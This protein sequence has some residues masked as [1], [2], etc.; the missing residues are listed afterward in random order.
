MPAKAVEKQE[1]VKAPEK[2]FF[3]GGDSPKKDIA[4][5]LI[6]EFRISEHGKKIYP[7]TTI[8]HICVVNDPETGMP[9]TMRLLKGIKTFWVD[10]QENVSDKM[11]QN[12]AEDI[13]ITDG[14]LKVSVVDKLK[15]DFLRRHNS[16]INNPNRIN[17][18][19]VLFEMLQ[20]S[21][22]QARNFDAENKR[23]EAVNLARE[24]G[25]DEM[26]YHATYLNIRLVDENGYDL[27]LKGL[28]AAYMK[29]ASADPDY[30]ISTFGTPDLKY[31]YLIRRLI[32]ENEIVVDLG[33]L[34]A[35]W[36]SGANICVLPEGQNPEKYLAGFIFTENG[37]GFK[38]RLDHIEASA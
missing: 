10:E 13:V 16:C 6:G 36:R 35:K 29:A 30:F 28:R 1:P 7:R 20:P 21:D 14:I 37:A 8:S 17:N 19:N 22:E 11:A 4:F 33:A 34:T 18:T 27:S 3:L 31:N 24:A 9:R 5:R 23:M 38:Q 2:K 12:L 15:I 25:E 32:R 26:V